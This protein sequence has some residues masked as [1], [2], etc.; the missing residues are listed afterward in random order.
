MQ[1]ADPEKQKGPGYMHFPMSY[2]EEY[3]KQFT[4][5]RR[6]LK[7]NGRGTE[8]VQKKN[9]NPGKNWGRQPGDVPYSLSGE[10]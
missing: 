7:K 9:Q 3:F 4:G 1:G 2:N 8:Y 5:E 10:K 6:V